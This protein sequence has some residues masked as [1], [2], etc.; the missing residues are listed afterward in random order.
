MPRPSVALAV[1][2]TKVEQA[3]ADHVN[4]QLPYATSLALNNTARA[5]KT[6]LVAEMRRVFESPVP[7]T[8]NS[9]AVVPST[10]SYPV[11]QVGFKD[12]ASTNRDAA[13]YLDPEVEGGDRSV[14][15]IESW[16]RARGALPDDMFV[17]P[18]EGA[19]LDAYGNI[20]RSQYGQIIKQLDTGWSGPQ[21][22]RRRS[23]RRSKR[24]AGAG[25]SY[26][27]G[28]PGGRP[29]G[30]WARI[31]F[32]HGSAVKPILMFIRQPH[33]SKRFGFYDI[34]TSVVNDEFPVQLRS[35]IDTALLTAR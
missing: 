29:L 6:A 18:G 26:F 7:Y 24:T 2:T 22:A 14:K 10:K 11:A 33:Y 16:L 31:Q 9:L 34:A 19:Q 15:G 25:Q 13:S 3:F 5:V 8:L 30:V 1:D 21:P 32:A 12:T 28:Q 4:N 23:A 27:I 35:A 20:S 17:A